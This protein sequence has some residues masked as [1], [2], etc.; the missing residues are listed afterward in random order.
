LFRA[1]N[2]PIV[3]LGLTAI[4][5]DCRIEHRDGADMR[6][7]F[8]CG[9]AAL[10]W[11]GAYAAEKSAKRCK[12]ERLQDCDRNMLMCKANRQTCD[13]ARDLA[14]ALVV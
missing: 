1:I 11:A 4:K 14:G 2:D 12:I 13:L 3:S 5:T 6:E 10:Y 7:P 8:V 9:L